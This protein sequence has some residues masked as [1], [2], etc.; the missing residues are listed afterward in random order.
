MSKF[1]EAQKSIE[2][3]RAGQQVE[4]ELDAVKK[5]VLAVNAQTFVEKLREFKKPAIMRATVLVIVLWTFMQICGFNSVLFY[6]E[7]ILVQGKS[8]LIEPKVVVMYASASA[9][10]ASVFSIIMIDRCGR[11]VLFSVIISLFL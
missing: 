6:M 3:Y 9:V 1:E 7:I 5:F 10:V 2:F 8:N 4:E 11:S